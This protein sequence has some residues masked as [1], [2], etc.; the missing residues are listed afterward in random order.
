MR[1]RDT[2]T[3]GED[4]REGESVR[5]DKEDEIINECIALTNSLASP[6]QLGLNFN[7]SR[8]YTYVVS[9]ITCAAR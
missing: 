9:R 6:R 1:E 2:E 4:G 5:R 7:V 8:G 3:R